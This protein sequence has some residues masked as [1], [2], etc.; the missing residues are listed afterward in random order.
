MS[1]HFHEQHGLRYHPAYKVWCNL[2]TRCGNKRHKQFP[3]YG[4]RGIDVCISWQNSFAAFWHDMGVGYRPGLTLD[5]TNNDQGYSKANCRWVSQGVNNI[6]RRNNVFVTTSRG[7]MTVS[8][9]AKLFSV[10]YPTVYSR[11]WRGLPCIL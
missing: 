8:E 4:G 5:R 2:K 6:N 9:A 1:I 10:P 11:H 3:D 7:R